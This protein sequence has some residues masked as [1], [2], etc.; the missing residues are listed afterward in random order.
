MNLSNI[1]DF[2]I[3]ICKT[4]YDRLW[5][6]LF[7]HFLREKYACLSGLQRKVIFSTL[8]VLLMGGVLYYPVMLLY[9]SWGHVR[10]S[11]DK[12]QLIRQMNHLSFALRSG[13][14]FIHPI[15]SS[16]KVFIQQQVSHWPL[17]K[18]QMTQVSE[19]KIDISDVNAKNLPV[20]SRLVEVKMDNLNL[21][22]TVEHAKRLEDL[23]PYLKLTNLK[24]EED[25]EKQDYFDVSYTLAFFDRLDA[26]VADKGKANNRLNQQTGSPS[27]VR[28]KNI[29]IDVPPPPLS[30][31]KKKDV[32]K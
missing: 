28:G 22:E 10:D 2:F 18:R 29:S 14:T 17:A 13:S 4:V 11:Q 3:D 15:H 6:N 23:S 1:K 26:Q 24:M 5:S 25:K 21:K 16:L 12:K 30:L 32:L 7:V 31:P 20:T 19:I 8:F 27:G 9:S